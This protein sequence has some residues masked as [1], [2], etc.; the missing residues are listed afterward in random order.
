MRVRV[1]SDRHPVL[2]YTAARAALF[3]ASYALLWLTGLRGLLLIVVALLVS[4][5]VSLWLLALQRDAMSVAVSRKLSAI[6][7]QAGVEDDDPGRDG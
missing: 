1:L 6:D 5:L 3:A 7:D 2:A 4:W